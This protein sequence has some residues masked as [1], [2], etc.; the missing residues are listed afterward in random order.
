MF[1]GAG[2][3]HVTGITPALSESAAELALEGARVA[4]EKGLKVSCDL[5][6]RKNLWKWGKSAGE[7]MPELVRSTDVVIA[8]EED[9]QTTL[10]IA[11]DIDVHA[12]ELDESAYQRLTGAVLVLLIVVRPGNLML[13]RVAIGAIALLVIVVSLPFRKGAAIAVNWLVAART[14]PHAPH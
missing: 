14:D 10:G 3:F 1:S 13:G 7:V 5:N 8:N 4:K 9:I 12:G 11:A 6:Y 2:W